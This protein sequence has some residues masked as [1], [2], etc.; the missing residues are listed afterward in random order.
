LGFQDRVAIVTGGASG[1]G[2][3][4]VMRFVEEGCRVVIPD[5]NG[6]AAATTA[7][8]IEKKYPG[9]AISLQVDVTNQDDVKRM[10]QT[11]L[12]QWGR[13][14][15]LVNNAGICP[16][17]AFEDLTVDMWDKVMT[18]NLRSMFLCTQAV[19]SVMSKAGYGKIVN[20]ASFAGQAGGIVAPVNYSAS[21]GGVISFT[22]ALARIYSSKGININAV[23]PGTIRTPMTDVFPPEGKARLVATIPMG[24]LGEA[25]EVADG[26][27]YLASDRASY[28]TGQVLSIN[29]GNYMG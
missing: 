23:A 13:V 17:V 1:L 6:P 8:D 21:K 24:R 5:I 26:V 15:I 22:R 25:E 10:I 28:V 9:S 20:I 2:K 14:D 11:V 27:V 7:A 4:M 16:V 18:V 29:G 3:A 12:G 19:V